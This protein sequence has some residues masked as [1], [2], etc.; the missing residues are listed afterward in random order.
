MRVLVTGMGGELGTRVAQL[1]EERDVGDGA[2]E[3]AQ[4]MRG[5]VERLE[6]VA[7]RFERI[8]RPLRREVAVD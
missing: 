5:D 8:G 2:R 1:L 7:H 4:L 6:R 3:T